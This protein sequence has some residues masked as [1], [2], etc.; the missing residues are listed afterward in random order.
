MDLRTQYSTFGYIGLNET[1]E[2]LG[3]NILKE[4]GLELQLRIIEVIN[5][6]NDLLTEEFNYP[7][8][9]EQIIIETLAIKLS[10]K[11]KVYKT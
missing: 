3:F 9:C 8:N 4:E 11:D 5:T 1:V 2:E 7:H 10:E 6:T